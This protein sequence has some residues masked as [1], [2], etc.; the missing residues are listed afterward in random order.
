MLSPREPERR[1]ERLLEDGEPAPFEVA[2]T[3]ARSPFVIACDHASRRIPRKL[4]RLGLPDA[5]L[6]RHIAWDIGAAGLARKLAAKL[7]AWLVL[8]NYS[9]LVIDCNRRL[10]RPDSIAVRSEDTPIPGNQD[11][12]PHDAELRARE[13]FEPY[14]AR[15]RRELDERAGAGRASILLFVHTFTPVFRS[16]P[17]VWH[18]GVLYHRDTR[19]ALPLLGALRRESGL[20]IGDNQPYAA[21]A[22]TD[23]GIIVHGEERG[24]PHV[25]LEVRQDLVSDDEGQEAWAERLAR[26]I[27]STTRE[28]GL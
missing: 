1:D 19:L 10:E 9:R 24:L 25:E 20:E 22:L 2:G 4:A 26:L 16:V 11:V 27:G 12:G 15:I 6:E 7:D 13:I 3:G 18:A 17:R 28:L 8:Q 5:E 21:T 14:H 23:Y